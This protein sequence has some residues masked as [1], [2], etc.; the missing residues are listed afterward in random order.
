[1]GHR[2]YKSHIISVI[3]TKSK[4]PQ[5]LIWC[6]YAGPDYKMVGDSLLAGASTF[7]HN[8][9]RPFSPTSHSTWIFLPLLEEAKLMPASQSCMRWSLSH[10]QTW[11]TS[12]LPQKVFPDSCKAGHS[13]LPHITLGHII[14]FSPQDLNHYLTL[15]CSLHICTVT[16]L[17]HFNISSVKTG[18]LTHRFPR[19]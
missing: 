19:A 7:L 3:T 16:G 18:D 15:P 6:Q 5:N 17:P 9:G 8:L 2:Y 4:A 1:M 11:S 10:E 14:L 13:T 12:R